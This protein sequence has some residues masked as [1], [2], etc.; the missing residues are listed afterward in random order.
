MEKKRNDKNQWNTK[1]HI[2]SDPGAI[3]FNS[4]IKQKFMFAQNICETR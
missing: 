3:N 2:T 4:C 1:T